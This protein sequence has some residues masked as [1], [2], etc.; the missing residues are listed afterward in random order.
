MSERGELTSVTAADWF[1]AVSGGAAVQ[2]SGKK[3]KRGGSGNGSLREKSSIP[4]RYRKARQ[5]FYSFLTQD[6]VI[7]GELCLCTELQAS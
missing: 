1:S 5:E 6:G 7:G 3:S 2:G 4:S